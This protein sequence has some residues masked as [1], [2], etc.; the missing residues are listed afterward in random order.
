VLI[1]VVVLS[2]AL[3]PVLAELGKVTG[4]WAERRFSVPEDVSSSLDEP[5]VGQERMQVRRGGAR[6]LRSVGG[7]LAG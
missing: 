4:D 3:T 2:M 7:R 5:L 6:G 1:I